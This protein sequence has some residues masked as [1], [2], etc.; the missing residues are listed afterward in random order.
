[1]INSIEVHG[2]SYEDP[3]KVKFEVHQH[4][5]KQFAEDLAKRP[6]LGG[7]FKTIGADYVSHHLVSEFSEFEVLAA[8][9]DCNN[10]KGPGPDGFYLLCY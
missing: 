5:K 2:A 1:M 3:N 8:I 4:F 10:N 6:V 7:V 9:K